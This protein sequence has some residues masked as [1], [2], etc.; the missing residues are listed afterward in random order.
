MSSKAHRAGVRAAT[1]LGA[2]GGSLILASG[3][4]AAQV[5]QRT[6]VNILV[7]CSKIEDPTARLACFDNNIRNVNPNLPIPPQV[8]SPIGASGGAP[9]VLQGPRGFG[10][11]DVRA[12]EEQRLAQ[13]AL[14]PGGELDEIDARVTAIVEREP[15]K[16]LLT[17]EDGAQWL[18]TDTVSLSYRLPRRGS[19]V[20]IE[21]AAANSF[22]MRF[23][24]QQ[25]VRIERVR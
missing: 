13:R 2:V 23:D 15:G 8:G 10:S 7:E 9:G 3:P 20:N 16:Y 24:S 19:I 18:F 11:E 17:L 5:D 21:R 22:L 6:A 4:A 1:I 25:S 12:G 14:I